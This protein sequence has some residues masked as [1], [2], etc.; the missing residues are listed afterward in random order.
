MS[1]DLSGVD[2]PVSPSPDA[3]PFW[4]AAARGELVLPR[5]DA[6]HG[7]VWY[8]R[9][10][11]PSCGSRELSW[12]PATGRGAVHAFCIHHVSPLPHIRE[13][14][15]VVTALVELEEGPRLMG[16][17]DA[18]PDPAAVRCGM[19]VVVRFDPTA[20]DVTVPVFVPQEED[21]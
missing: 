7:W 20:G 4:E 3:G 13:L 17:L 9:V 21:Q 14:A 10:V 15:P 1:L 11:C 19:P 6:C 16:F 12:V 8:P 18:D 5:C 2:V